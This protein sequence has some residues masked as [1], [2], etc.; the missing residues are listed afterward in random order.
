MSRRVDPYE[1]SEQ[2]G[3]RVDPCER[4]PHQGPLTLRCAV[5]EV[6]AEGY[7]HE[8]G[9]PGLGVARWL[10]VPPGWWVLLDCGKPHV[11]CPGCLRIG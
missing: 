11:R 6:E 7:L 5:C 4:E 10:A 9:F 2:I 1:G 8:V 3:G